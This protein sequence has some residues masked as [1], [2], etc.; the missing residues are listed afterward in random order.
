[1][2]CK[3]NLSLRRALCVYVIL[4]A[5]GLFFGPAHGQSVTVNGLPL[6]APSEGTLFS[7]NGTLTSAWSQIQQQRAG[8]DIGEYK[9]NY[10]FDVE[11]DPS[12]VSEED[13]CDAEGNPTGKKY[14][15]AKP[16]SF[17]IT[18]N[19]SSQALYPK[20]TD[21]QNYATSCPSAVTEWNK[22]LGDVKTHEGLHHTAAKTFYTEQKVKS[23]FPGPL[24]EVKSGCFDPEKESEVNAA[25]AQ[26]FDAIKAQVKPI[27]DKIEADAKLA[28]LTDMHH[29][30]GTTVIDTSKDCSNP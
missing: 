26:V 4:A 23:Y 13:C 15:V 24:A 25:R 8:K 27:L 20:W 16:D 14:Y 28:D 22:F 29:P 9:I 30:P 12:K 7:V 2:F 17:I 11:V 21:E 5:A 6:A 3:N 10:P 19:Y 1:M 18:V